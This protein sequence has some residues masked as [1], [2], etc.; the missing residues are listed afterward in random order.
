MCRHWTTIRIPF[1]PGKKSQCCWRAFSS[2]IRSDTCVQYVHV[3]RFFT[4]EDLQIFQSSSDSTAVNLNMQT[5][6]MRSFCNI[7]RKKPCIILFNY[8]ENM[9]TNENGSLDL[10]MLLRVT[11]GYGEIGILFTCC[12]SV[13]SGFTTALI[14]AFRPSRPPQFT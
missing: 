9:Q 13:D 8:H 4:R 7:L 2:K 12:R 1:L 14:L 5:L 3:F 6:T 11:A 10:G